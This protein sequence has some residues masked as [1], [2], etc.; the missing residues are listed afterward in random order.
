MLKYVIF[1]IQDG[2]SH[3]MR[4]QPVPQKRLKMFV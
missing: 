1:K 2:G 3:R 4:K